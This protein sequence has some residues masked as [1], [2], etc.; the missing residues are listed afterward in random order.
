M[1]KLIFFGSIALLVLFFIYLSKKYRSVYYILLFSA[2]S[3]F[4]SGAFYLGK[5]YEKFSEQSALCQYSAQL[6]WCFVGAHLPILAPMI[7]IIG[8]LV[9]LLVV[10]ESLEVRSGSDE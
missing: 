1:S 9:F 7:L 2:A 5:S 10:I 6:A 8:G 3:T 4:G